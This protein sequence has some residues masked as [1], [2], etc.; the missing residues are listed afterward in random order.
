MPKNLHLKHLQPNEPNKKCWG[1]SF[2]TSHILNILLVALFTLT[3]Q[4]CATSTGVQSSGNNRYRVEGA[5]EFGLSAAKDAAMEDAEKFC[6][7][8]QRVNQISSSN[9]S[10]VDAF[11]DRVQTWEL[12]FQCESS[13][14]NANRTAEHLHQQ[15]EPESRNYQRERQAQAVTQE[16]DRCTLGKL[17]DQ[18]IIH[19][20]SEALR[21]DPRGFLLKPEARTDIFFNRSLAYARLKDYDRAIAD[22]QAVLRIAPGDREA[23]N[24]MANLTSDRKAFNEQSRR[25]SQPRGPVPR[26]PER[27]EI[28]LSA[29]ANNTVH[30]NGRQIFEQKSGNNRINIGQFFKSGANTVVIRRKHVGR[31]GGQRAIFKRA[32]R[33]VLTLVPKDLQPIAMEFGVRKNLAKIQIQPKAGACW[34]MRG[35]GVISG[36]VRINRRS[37]DVSGWERCEDYRY[38]PPTPIVGHAM[39]LSAN[40]TKHEYL[41]ALYKYFIK[42]RVK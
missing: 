23:R 3:L 24:I 19:A 34:I 9:D 13:S 36:N 42:P 20:C 41:R 26:G 2:E 18:A 6:D 5:S 12:I 1:R 11:G 10:H 27:W 40:P 15:D 14:D 37:I 32:G 25:Q 31:T 30:V 28:E 21:L 38:L 4:G 35:W 8:P 39:P 29:I 22:I 17:N 16:Y 7:S 33:T